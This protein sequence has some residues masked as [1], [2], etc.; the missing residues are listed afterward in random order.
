M[1]ELK[2]ITVAFKWGTITKHPHGKLTF[3]VNGQTNGVEY[4]Y[5]GSC[6][7][8]ASEFNEKLS[9][10]RALQVLVL[11]RQTVRYLEEHDPKAL[12]QAR[13]ALRA[14]GVTSEPEPL[15]D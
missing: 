7:D 8:A 3:M 5:V 4:D 13:S 6:L 12:E 10:V 2:Q 9:V 15:D 11:T 14:I 1:T